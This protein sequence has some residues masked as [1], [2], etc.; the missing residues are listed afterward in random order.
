MELKLADGSKRFLDAY[1][2]IDQV[3]TF[4]LLHYPVL[5]YWVAFGLLL[6][7]HR[8]V[9]FISFL[10]SHSIPITSSTNSQVQN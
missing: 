2:D 5:F 6:L 10:L 1:K 9:S 7:I 4:G 8:I 3:C